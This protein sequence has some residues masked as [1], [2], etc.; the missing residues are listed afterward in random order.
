MFFVIDWH[1]FSFALEIVGESMAFFLS[2]LF[3][4]QG[5]WFG[6]GRTCG[7]C[8]PWSFLRIMWLQG[9]FLSYDFLLSHFLLLVSI[10]NFSC[11][12]HC[13]LLGL[14]WEIMH[15]ASLGNFNTTIFSLL[16]HLIYAEIIFVTWHSS[17][18]TSGKFLPGKIYHFS[19]Y[20]IEATVSFHQTLIS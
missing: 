15:L 19:Q 14:A 1:Y 8:P 18:E 7:K 6:E 10:C 20:L 5:S 11:R 13:Y 3:V 16:L 2:I 17:L 4:W 12:S 9:V